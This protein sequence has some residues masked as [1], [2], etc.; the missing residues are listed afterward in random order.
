MKVFYFFI[1]ASTYLPIETEQ[2][3]DIHITLIDISFC[4]CKNLS[5]QLKIAYYLYYITF[6]RLIRTKYLFVKKMKLMSR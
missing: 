4:F 5:L 3:V 6:H 2:H 1:T